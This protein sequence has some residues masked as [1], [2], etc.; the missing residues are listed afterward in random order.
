MCIKDQHWLDANDKIRDQ[1]QQ[2]H[3]MAVQNLEVLT[4]EEDKAAE[5]VSQPSDND[6]SAIIIP[7]DT[8]VTN[9]VISHDQNQLLL[10]PNDSLIQ[11]PLSL[12]SGLMI[13][14]DAIVSA[15]NMVVYGGGCT[16]IMLVNG[17]T[18]KLEQSIDP[19]TG[20][21][22]GVDGLESPLT[23]MLRQHHYS[24]TTYQSGK[25]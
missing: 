2:Q 19:A 5:S 11:T 24:T 9:T 8:N 21:A 16:G 17:Q 3:E 14:D 7:E 12:Q 20:T 22:H 4:T 23:G 15:E 1:F 10:S 13:G 6:M 25:T 18:V